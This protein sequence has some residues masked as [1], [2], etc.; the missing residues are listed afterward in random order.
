MDDRLTTAIA[1]LGSGP[2]RPGSSAT[3]GYTYN[4]LPFPGC[5]DIPCHRPNSPERWKLIRSS[6]SLK[7]KVVLDIGCATG[8]FSFKAIQ[9]GAFSVV[10][11][12]SDSAA[13]EVCRAAAHVFSVHNA[14][15]RC[16][17]WYAPFGSYFD[18]AFALSVLNLS[19]IHI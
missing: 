13:I 18:V 17:D 11:V 16:E 2:Y 15:F 19:L 14:S 8:Y 9:N 12:D 10:A 4:P 3:K 6:I 1:N 5:E 7:N